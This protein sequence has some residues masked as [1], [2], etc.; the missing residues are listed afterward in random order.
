MSTPCVSR[1]KVT[2][3]EK[4][5][6]KVDFEVQRDDAFQRLEHALHT[7]MSVGATFQG[8]FESGATRA[9]ATG[10]ASAMRLVLEQVFDVDAH[11]LYK[12]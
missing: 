2:L 6:P 7:A 10:G 11:L 9:S 5:R 3:P 4:V 12:K 8:R 1:L